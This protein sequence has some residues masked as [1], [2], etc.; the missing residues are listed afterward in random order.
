MENSS[1]ELVAPAPCLVVDLAAYRAASPAERNKMAKPL[2]KPSAWPDNDFRQIGSLLDDAASCIRKGQF[3]NPDAMAK[4]LNS[5]AVSA[6]R[7]AYGVAEMEKR[8]RK[9]TKARMEKKLR[10]ATKKLKKARA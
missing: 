7:A 9:D 2:F 5:L 3:I 10:K 4:A 8:V 1:P 6:R